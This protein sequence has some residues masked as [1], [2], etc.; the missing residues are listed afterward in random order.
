MRTSRGFLLLSI[1]VCVWLALPRLA[2]GRTEPGPASDLWSLAQREAQI[3]RFS[4]LFSAQDVRDHLG[5]EDGIEKAIQWCKQTGITKL[6]VESYRDG[7]RAERA[8][9]LNARG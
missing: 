9:L 8:A 5:N 4:T 3:H 1:L 6:Y 7:Y 2:A